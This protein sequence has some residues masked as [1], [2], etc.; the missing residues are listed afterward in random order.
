M[1]LMLH[2]AHGKWLAQFCLDCL[3]ER[4]RDAENSGTFYSADYPVEDMDV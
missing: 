1:V 4:Q 3:V 2:C